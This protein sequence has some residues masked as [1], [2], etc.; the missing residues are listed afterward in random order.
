[1]DKYLPDG[2]CST[3]CSHLFIGEQFLCWIVLSVLRP[4]GPTLTND[5]PLDLSNDFLRGFQ[6][7]TDTNTVRSL[8]QGQHMSRLTSD[9]L[10]L[11]HC[12]VH[13]NYSLK[14]KLLEAH[15]TIKQ[16]EFF[17]TWEAR[18][19]LISSIN[20]MKKELAVMTTPL[21]SNLNILL[22]ILKQNLHS[23]TGASQTCAS[24]SVFTTQSFQVTFP[25]DSPRPLEGLFNCWTV[26]W[27]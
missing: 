12:N 20:H 9:K 24:S 13:C 7:L 15:P 19:I 10:S 5:Y 27:N 17:S 18:Q 4:N 11:N 2:Q 6:S 14:K 21:L 25:A 26:S 1:M 23:E 22:I 3:F 16:D 8:L